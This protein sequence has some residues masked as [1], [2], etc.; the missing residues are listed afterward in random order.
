MHDDG[1]PED[2]LAALAASPWALLLMGLLVLGDAFLVVIPGEVAV[3]ALGAL[4]AS[5]GAPP[6]VAVIVVAGV[7]AFVGDLCLYAIGRTVGLERSAW[8]RRPRVKAAFDAAARRLSRS[9][10]AVAFTA[11]FIPFARIAVNLTAGAART[12]P[13]YLVAAGCAAVGW[14]GYQA[15][16][17]AAVALIVPGGPVVAV[18]VSIVV[19]LVLGVAI[20]A[21]V[22][23][24]AGRR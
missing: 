4:A 12:G 2:A 17:G 15:V 19:A 11:R 1:V 5:T 23:R 21:L 7:A 9:A 6:L 10:T 22:A 18:L 3:T 16:I 14:A 8:M 24:F 20:D 13:R